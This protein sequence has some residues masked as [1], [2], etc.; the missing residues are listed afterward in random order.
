MNALAV[1]GFTVVVAR[2]GGMSGDHGAHVGARGSL[3]PKAV[4]GAIW[5]GLAIAMASTAASVLIG[6]AI[7]RLVPADGSARE[8]SALIVVACELPLMIAVV[9]PVVARLLGVRRPSFFAIP[10]AWAVCVVL[11][12]AVEKPIWPFND[13]LSSLLILWIP[14]P[15]ISVWILQQGAGGGTPPTKRHAPGAPN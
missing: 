12:S 2:Y 11:V 13:P 15:L 1:N 6:L 4:A 14:Y 10:A 5:R 9:G 8:L 3:T 7:V